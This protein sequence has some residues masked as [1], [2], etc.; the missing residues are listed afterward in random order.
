MTTS[1][2]VLIVGLQPQLID[3][4]APDFAAFPGLNADKVLEGLNTGVRSLAALGYDA[5][6]CLTDF[7]DTAEDVLRNEL[8]A[9]KYDCVMVGAGVRTVDTHFL[10][11]EKIINIIHEYAP[12]AR[13]CFNTKP[14]DTADAVKRWV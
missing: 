2:H 6:L 8:K 12:D 1:K 5:S 4:S 10:L 7:G 3:F 9:K 14:S 13:I 11:F